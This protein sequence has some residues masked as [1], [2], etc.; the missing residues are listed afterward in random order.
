MANSKAVTGARGGVL[1][2]DIIKTVEQRFKKVKSEKA[3]RIK[4]WK[5]SLTDLTEDAKKQ[6]RKY[7]A[8][9]QKATRSVKNGENV[10]ENQKKIAELEGKINKLD[11]DKYTNKDLKWKQRET[12]QSIMA[13][14]EGKLCPFCG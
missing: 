5:E 9:I 1:K 10:K 12:M 14:L 2:K 6:K 11:K 8:E 4:E 7:T 13:D 3:R